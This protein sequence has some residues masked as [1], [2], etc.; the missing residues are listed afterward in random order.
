MTITYKK[1]WKLLIDRDK[2]KAELRE[3]TGV[4]ASKLGNKADYDERTHSFILNTNINGCPKG[5]CRLLSGTPQIVLFIV[6]HIP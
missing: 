4:G 3:L 1:L 5:K 2:S 6:C